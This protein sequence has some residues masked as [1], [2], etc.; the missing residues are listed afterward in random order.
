M[1]IRFGFPPVVRQAPNP[2]FCEIRVLLS[3]LFYLCSNMD[4]P[5]AEPLICSPAEAN[6]T[7]KGKKK[8]HRSVWD[9]WKVLECLFQ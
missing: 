3:V 2:S 4:D 1:A 7:I 5:H 8:V 6:G 9:L